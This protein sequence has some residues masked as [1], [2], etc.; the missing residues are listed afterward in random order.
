V[1]EINFFFEIAYILFSFAMF[2]TI[3][4]CPIFFVVLKIF[5]HDLQIDYVKLNGFVFLYYLPISLIFYF[6]PSVILLSDNYFIT[7]FT[8]FVLC[9]YNAPL[10]YLLNRYLLGQKD[11][12]SSLI[13]F[14]MFI[15]VELTIIYTLYQ[16]LS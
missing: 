14:M 16:L 9:I 8:I 11:L 2:I 15:G 13:I 12:K 4:L 1:F 7:F 5:Y 6:F 3:F 10:T